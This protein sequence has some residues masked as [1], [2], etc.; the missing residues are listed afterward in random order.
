M[1][2][3]LAGRSVRRIRSEQ[4]ED[5]VYPGAPTVDDVCRERVRIFG[6]DGT[7][8]ARAIGYRSR[9]VSVGTWHLEERD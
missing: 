5:V 4:D 8:Y 7:A 2:R 1:R 9:I 6:D 3:V